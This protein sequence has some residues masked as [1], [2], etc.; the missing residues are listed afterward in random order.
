VKEEEMSKRLLVV[1]ILIGVLLAGCSNLVSGSG[2]LV[3]REENLSGFDR[4]VAGSAFHVNIRQGDSFR[5]V[6]RV[7][8]NVASYLEVVRQGDTLRIGLRP[9]VWISNATL[10]ADITMPELTG[11]ELSGASQG[12][13]DGFKSTKALVVNL[14]GASSL[15]GNI[16][17][18]T[19]QV[20]TSGASRVNLTGAG[21]DLKAD[22]SGA[23]SVDLAGF[24]VGDAQVG[25]S[26]ASTATVAPSGRLDV[27]AS[28]A[29]R[30]YYLGSP[31]MGDIETSGASS[32]GAK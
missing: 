18:G 1:F 16:E 17:A 25:V 24:P 5:V 22:I 13:I 20:E 15:Q 7:D 10:Q 6:V 23:S 19:V 9:G 12:V 8:D 28:G 26:G 27:H 3:T 32:I 4:V 21:R 2:N 31:T 14:S 29:S 30:V 11:L